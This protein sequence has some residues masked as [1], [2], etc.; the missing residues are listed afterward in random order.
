MSHVTWQ[1]GWAWAR[2]LV[3]RSSS[4][5]I[6]RVN[7][8]LQGYSLKQDIQA[9]RTAIKGHPRKAGTTEFEVA[10]LRWEA[11]IHAVQADIVAASELPPMAELPPI[12]GSHLQT[13][14]C[15]VPTA[16]APTQVV[17]D[18]FTRPHWLERHEAPTPA[19]VQGGMPFRQGH[20][21]GDRPRLVNQ[22]D[23]WPTSV[24]TTVA[25]SFATAPPSLPSGVVQYMYIQ[26]VAPPP[27]G[28][29]LQ[30]FPSSGLP[31]STLAG[32]VAAVP[33]VYS[34]HAA[35]AASGLQW[36]PVAE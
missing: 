25:K 35:A 6:W 18:A 16:A 17:V 27:Q 15:S 19:A 5:A 34:V 28:T 12:R 3:S 9:A 31:H 7:K 24:P 30:P 29:P 33:V 10:R 14:S 2:L 8:L 26:H 1:S 36:R 13:K 20:A 11:E 32:H 4:A 21:T 23:A 22:R